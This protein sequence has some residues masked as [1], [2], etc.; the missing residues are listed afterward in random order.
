MPGGCAQLLSVARWEPPV[1]NLLRD[2]V[3]YGNDFLL[4]GF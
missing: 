4:A 3:D 1:R 2:V